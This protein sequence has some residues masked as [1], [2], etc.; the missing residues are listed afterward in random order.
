MMVIP[1]SQHKLIKIRKVNRRYLTVLALYC[2]IMACTFNLIGTSTNKW[3]YTSEVLKYYVMP[4]ISQTYDD[5]ANQPTYFKNASIGP[6]RYCWLDPVHDFHCHSVEYLA[7]DDPS[8][9]TTSVQQSTRRSFPF[10]M[11]GMLLDVLGLG[12]SFICY[13]LPTPYASLLTSTLIHINAGIANFLCI[14]VYM[15][16][17]SKEVGNRIHP[18]SEMDDPLFHF[19][20]GYSFIFLKASF[21]L[22]EMAALFSIMVYMAKRDERTFNRY[23]LRSLL[24]T[25]TNAVAAAQESDEIVISRENAYHHARFDNVRTRGSSVSNAPSFE[26]IMRRSPPPPSALRTITQDAFFPAILMGRE[27]ANGVMAIKRT[28]LAPSQTSNYMPQKPPFIGSEL[29]I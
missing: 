10:M 2:S 3:L 28:S 5:S 27:S 26:L 1:V 16:A 18:A 8:D 9:V 6:W 17:V 13:R 11:T 4:N 14:I 21:L 20:Y 25:H 29:H 15:S 12:M 19:Q 22:T 7:D 23:K 24:N